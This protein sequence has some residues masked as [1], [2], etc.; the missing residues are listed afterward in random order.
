MY[1]DLGELLGGSKG[2]PPTKEAY[3]RYLTSV[4]AAQL[5]GSAVVAAADEVWES[6][7]R[8][9]Q[10]PAGDTGGASVGLLPCSAVD[11]EALMTIPF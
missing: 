9:S 5:P 6:I 10:A 8:I 7:G 2:S 11:L 4:S 3:T 1:V